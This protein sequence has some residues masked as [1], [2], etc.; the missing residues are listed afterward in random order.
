MEK[1]NKTILD[2]FQDSTP[3]S[4]HRPHKMAIDQAASMAP[5]KRCIPCGVFGDQ[6]LA[7]SVGLP[8]KFQVL[9]SKLVGGLEHQFYFPIYWEQSSQLTFIFFRGVAQPPT[10]NGCEWKTPG[11]WEEDSLEGYYHPYIILFR[12]FWLTIWS[13]CWLVVWNINF[14]FPYI[15]FLIIPIDCHIF[16][17]GSNHQPDIVGSI[18][19][20]MSMTFQFSIP[21]VFPW[22]EIS[23]L[24]GVFF[25]KLYD[26]LSP[27]VPTIVSS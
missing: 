9:K 6:V 1:T 19:H 16:Q 20:D 3:D 8:Q 22:Q 25:F 27:A 21:T 18:F 14:I 15:G 23:H 11:T 7:A 4:H 24:S 2:P 26:I 10:S 5:T 13:Y 12:I 17:R